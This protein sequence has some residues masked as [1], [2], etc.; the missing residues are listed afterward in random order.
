M[1]AGVIGEDRWFTLRLPNHDDVLEIDTRS[2]PGGVVLQVGKSTEQLKELL[3]RFRTIFIGIMIP[4]VLIGFIG[5]SFLAFRT[6][7]PIRDLIQ[8][9]R[10]ID[11]GKMDARVPSSR[12]GDEL[13]ELVNLFNGMLEKIKALIA[14]MHG[15][16]DN[17]AHDLRTPLTRM[18]SVVEKVLQTECDASTLRE[19]LVDCAEESERMVTMLKTLTDISEA[20]SGVMQLHLEKVNIASLMGS[21][22]ELY[23]YVAG[24]KGVSM[25]IRVPEE[26]YSQVDSNRM[27]QVVANLVDNAVKYTQAGGKVEIEASWGDKELGILIIDAGSGISPLNL[28]RIFDRLYRGDKSRTH[29]GLGLGLSVVQ[30]VIHAHKGR[31]QVCSQLGQGSRFAIHLALHSTIAG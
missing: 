30:A 21:V 29:R 18:R 4:V 11:T 15:A 22:V 1:V 26:L 16:L 23:Q 14:G 2:L 28:L 3:E 31:I 19:A 8:T 7:R 20:E 13:E 17:V 25:E 6:L 9:V 24:D 12:T 27:R 5:G 10:S